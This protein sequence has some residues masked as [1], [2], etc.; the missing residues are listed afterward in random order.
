MMNIR[1]EKQ[2]IMAE[3]RA[4]PRDMEAIKKE[5]LATL[6]AFP[7]LA[8]E[9]IYC[10]PVGKDNR[11]GQ[12]K[13]AENLSIRAAETIAEAYGYNEVTITVTDLPDDKAQVTCRM[14]DYQRVRIWSDSGILSKWYKSYNGPM[15][16]MPDDRFYSLICKA[17]ASKRVRECILR[18]VNAGLKAWYLDMCYQI[19]DRMV[20]P[21]DI[22]KIIKDFQGL[23]GTPA[24]VEYIVGRPRALGW[25]AADMRKL[26]GIRNAIRDGEMTLAD[27]QNRD[28][29]PPD[30]NKSK[31]D[32]LADKLATNGKKSAP[33]EAKKEP[34]Q[35]TETDRVNRERA[36]ANAREQTADAQPDAP[37]NQTVQPELSKFAAEMR[38]ELDQAIQGKDKKDALPAITRFLRKIDANRETG[39]LTT[40]DHGALY[41]Y[42]Q[43]QKERFGK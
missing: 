36:E 22:D 16:K 5:L 7:G 38:S 40:P 35:E 3:C 9:S 11:T 33:D 42:A 27:T 43:K 14:F 8:D 24:N 23:G 37:Q 32:E 34:P 12:E 15:K 28:A 19:L 21:E 4:R 26:I 13:Y 31:A 6:K 20:K 25:T 29:A 30:P 17:D 18:I 10:K 41:A 2:L 39:T 1:M